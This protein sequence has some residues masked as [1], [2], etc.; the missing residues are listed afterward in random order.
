ME[1]QTCKD[2]GFLL[3][4]GPRGQADP[5]VCWMRAARWPPSAPSSTTPRPR[6][7]RAPGRTGADTPADVP[8]GYEVVIRSHG[9]PRSIYDELD[10]R[11]CTYHDATC[12]FVKKIQKVASEAEAAGATLVVAGDVS[13]PEVQGIV[14]HTRGEV[15][16]FSDLAQL[17]AW[18]GPSDPPKAHFC[19]CTDHISGNK[20][21][22]K[23]GVSQKS[24]YKRPNF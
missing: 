21:A 9:V 16:V 20:M 2:C 1:S 17:K 3:R 12:P 11:G 7:P 4:R 22:R 19:S 10:A 5:T 23:F 15:F 24:L 6:R 13:H 18:K 8:A 14:G